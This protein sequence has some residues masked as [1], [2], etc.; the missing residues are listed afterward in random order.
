MDI[1]RIILQQLGGNRFLA[2]TGASH[3]AGDEHSLYMHLPAN[4]SKA[5]RLTITLDP[6]DTYTMRFYRYT[7]PRLNRKTFSFS[8]EKTTE[9]KTFSGLFFDQLQ[10]MFTDVTKMYTHL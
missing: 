1:P 3:L 10:E 7:A 4:G 5:N 9:V 8:A 6:D 2:M